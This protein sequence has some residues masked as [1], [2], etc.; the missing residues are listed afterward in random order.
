MKLN[1]HRRLILLLLLAALCTGCGTLTKNMKL[2]V[3]HAAADATI[4]LAMDYGL[5]NPEQVLEV[6]TK[7][8]EILND[9]TVIAD[10]VADIEADLPACP[11]VDAVVAALK[12]DLYSLQA[13][14]VGMRL[15]RIEEILA[16]CEG[17]AKR[18][19]K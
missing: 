16:A 1:L 3:T 4:T 7:I 19:R 12:L 2:C 10:I 5:T 11:V 18:W 6:V 9:K 15:Y 17:R 13:S 14:L 8:R